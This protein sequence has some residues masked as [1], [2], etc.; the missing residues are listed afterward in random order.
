MIYFTSDLHFYYRKSVNKVGSRI[1]ENQEEKNAFLIR[2]WNSIVQDSDSVYILGDFSDGNA[3]ETAGIL[4][5]LHGKKYLVIGNND[6]YLEDP[7][8]PKDLYEWTKPYF[9]LK[10]METKFVLFHYPIEAWSGYR[11]DRIHLHGH[12]HRLQAMYE[13][14]RRYEVGVDA[15]DGKPVSIDEIWESV[16]DCHN[17]NRKMPGLE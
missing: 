10:E 16:K 5:E 1:F 9:E 15:H 17:V 12:V 2:Q 3:E 4:R 6:H 8:F 11:N 13:P 14:I 7:A